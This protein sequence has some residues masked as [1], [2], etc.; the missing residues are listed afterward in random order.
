VRVL[1]KCG[2]VREGLERRYLCINAIWQDHLLFGLL[3]EDLK[4]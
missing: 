1:E 3:N 4:S 2:C